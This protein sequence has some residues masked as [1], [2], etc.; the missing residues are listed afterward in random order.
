MR[1]RLHNWLTRLDAHAVRQLAR[2]GRWQRAGSGAPFIKRRAVALLITLWIVVVLGVVASSLAFDVQV[3]SKL[4]L[5]QKEEFV[6]FNL[7]KSAVAVGITHLQND[8]IIDY[9]ENENQPFDAF[10]DVW[11][12]R[13]VRDKDRIVQ[14]DPKRHPD[15][16]YELEI[17]DEE[18]KIP[19]NHASFKIVKAMME[20][21]GFETPDSDDLAHAIIDYRDPDDMAS[22]EPGAFENEYYSNEL[23]QRVRAEMTSD[24]FIYRCPNEPFFTTEQLLDVYGFS[25]FPDV[26]YG[27]DPAEKLENERNIRDAIA[28]GR[29]VRERRERSR[30][31]REPLAVKD[32]VTVLPEGNGRVNMNTASVEVLTILF[33]AATDFA[34]ID[35]AKAAA[36]S[37]AEYRG[38][39]T[40]K[41]MDPDD[42][43]KSVADLSKV[44]GVDQGMIANISSL[45][46]Q[47]VFNSRTFRIIGKGTTRR[48][49]REIEVVVERRLEVYNPDDPNLKSNREG[50]RSARDRRSGSRR[51]RGDD[52]SDDNYIRVPAVRIMQWTD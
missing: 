34:S 31:G 6:A 45:G 12:Q 17:L 32:I 42:A 27:F 13:D 52:D 22:G 44:P 19:L 5:L 47:P 37:I 36:E 49:Y 35:A 38:D 39:G 7:A 25:D 41:V 18:G 24:Q 10:S 40:N 2:L 29:R 14:V 20:Y 26:Y 43:F 23:G 30:R 3:G 21:Y 51:E 28:S 8:M 4:A 15:R 33:H 16:T 50:R 11:A 48:A 9:K 46:I 1:N